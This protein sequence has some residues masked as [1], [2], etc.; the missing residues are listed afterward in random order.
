MH[1]GVGNAN[2]VGHV[3]RIIADKNLARPFE[4]L[5][6]CDSACSGQEVGCGTL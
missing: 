4:L 5:V 6:D 1:L 3:G 2:V